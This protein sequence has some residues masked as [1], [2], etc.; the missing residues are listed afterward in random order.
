MAAIAITVYL[1]VSELSL[2]HTGIVMIK[3]R[4]KWIPLDGTVLQLQVTHLISLMNI[5]MMGDLEMNLE[6]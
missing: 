2:S 3:S 6:Q 5:V 1:H 4:G